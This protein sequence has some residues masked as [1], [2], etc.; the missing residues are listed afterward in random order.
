[1]S[2][3]AI[4]ARILMYLA[5]CITIMVVGMSVITHYWKPL[6]YTSSTVGDYVDAYR[7]PDGTLYTDPMGY[8]MT[9]REK[10]IR[11]TSERVRF[12]VNVRM[13]TSS[14]E[15]RHS[16]EYRQ[17]GRRDHFISDADREQVNA[18][19]N[20]KKPGWLPA[21]LVQSGGAPVTIPHPPGVKHRIASMV[22]TFL[23]FGFFA[24][25]IIHMGIT[26]KGSP[27]YPEC[28]KCF[29]SLEGNE[30]GV[31]PECGHRYGKGAAG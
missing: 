18:V 7:L 11:E 15:T 29:Y 20:Q 21:P 3:W 25:A 13:Q 30:T 14:E 1:Y 6:P 2:G 10:E 5:V 17:S 19:L 31:C 4:A 16:V 9:A 12:D 23:T 22:L 27:A 26:H 8:P 24:V 28:P